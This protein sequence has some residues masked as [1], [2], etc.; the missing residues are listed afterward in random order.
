MADPIPAFLK[1]STGEYQLQVAED[2]TNRAK[3][4]TEYLETDMSP[5]LAVTGWPV[6]LAGLDA[7]TLHEAAQAPSPAETNL[8]L[9]SKG[10]D[11]LLDRY[12]KATQSSFSYP[13]V[14]RHLVCSTSLN[15]P[16]TH[17]MGPMLSLTTTKF[18]EYTQFWT[19]FIAYLLRTYQLPDVSRLVLSRRQRD[20]VTVLDG[21]LSNDERELIVDD[22]L[23]L[24]VSIL[25]QTLPRSQF[26]S[27]LLHFL[28]IMALNP[29][30]LTWMDAERYISVLS[31]VMHIGRI[32]IPNH[33][34]LTHPDPD[35]SSFKAYCQEHLA[36]DSLSAIQSV[37]ELHQRAQALADHVR[38]DIQCDWIPV[39]NSFQYEDRMISLASLRTLTKNLMKEARQTLWEKLV[40][41]PS[42][43]LSSRDA[44]LFKDD[45][46]R[47]TNGFSF[48]AIES[49]NLRDGTDRVLG[50][51]CQHDAFKRMVH[52]GSQPP[53][54]SADAIQEYTAVVKTFLYQL[55]LLCY[56]S[57]GYP[58]RDVN[59]LCMKTDNTWG[60]MRSIYL[61]RDRVC[62]ITRPTK[63][64]QLEIHYLPTCLGQMMIAY[65]VDV[66]PFVKFLHRLS[67]D[68]K[69]DGTLGRLDFTTSL[70]WATP[71]TE[72]LEKELNVMLTE[73]CGC[74]LGVPLG[75][76][77]WRIVAWMID[78]H[79]LHGG[80]QMAG[81]DEP[82][83][84]QHALQAKDG[85]QRLTETIRP[86]L[87]MTSCKDVWWHVSREWHQELGL[88]NETPLQNPNRPLVPAKPFALSS[89]VVPSATNAPVTMVTPRK[90][91][92][93]SISPGHGHADT[94]GMPPTGLN[95]DD[96]FS[97]TDQT[98]TYDWAF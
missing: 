73:L 45:M 30:D 91:P 4:P 85:V 50:W 21:N 6:H 86:D 84:P 43:Y 88:A 53:L 44:A 8:V 61:D 51:L 23:Q 94:T 83:H 39:R 70:I 18:Q 92:R 96:L 67:P 26:E 71:D 55:A 68:R 80:F 28:A 78:R 69:F 33:K 66:L 87:L 31:G 89:S 65:I 59:F 10:V 34:Y 5:W 48:A 9:M 95:S 15:D 11:T 98:P 63:A 58:P 72:A 46:L 35:I 54:F 7:Q 38:V 32:I 60:S 62:L 75:L 93:R 19:R 20:L 56:I 64:P 52:A 47:Q 1:S 40:F 57:A 3:L 2:A 24:S 29:A 36:D 76:K 37:R 97:D 49:N 13:A 25:E 82:G 42:Q 74:A 90:R 27:P 17:P 81:A 77:E 79:L 12:Q 16:A 22:I 14:T 41:Q